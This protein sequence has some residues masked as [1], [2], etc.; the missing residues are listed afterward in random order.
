MGPLT[1]VLPKE[2]LATSGF[3]A[4]DVAIAENAARER[5]SAKGD[6]HVYGPPFGCAAS[7]ARQHRIDDS[8]VAIRGDRE[9]L[10]SVLRKGVE[11]CGC[12]RPSHVHASQGRRLGSAF[13]GSSW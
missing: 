13:R 5:R 11:P 2:L 3:K 8:A 1:L 7:G 6:L 10:K 4:A 12:E 9:A